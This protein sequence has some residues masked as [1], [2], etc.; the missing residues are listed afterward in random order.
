MERS[1]ES[2]ARLLNLGPVLVARHLFHHGDTE[3]QRHRDTE[4]QRKTDA[5]KIEVEQTTT[6]IP[7]GERPTTSDR[8]PPSHHAGRFLLQLFRLEVRDQSVNQRLELTV[9]HLLE[10]VNGEAD[11]V[12]GEP[13]L[14]K[15]VGANL[16]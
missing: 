7:P 16:F 14:R 10:L 3:T 8:R 12:V 1:R 5:R 13:V 2:A 4:T 6:L 15:V 9:H 11:A